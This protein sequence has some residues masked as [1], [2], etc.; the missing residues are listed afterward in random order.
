MTT[1]TLSGI[2]YYPVKGCAGT[3]LP[4][5][6][7]TAAG[8]PHDRAY[9]IADEK[10]D[11][12]W[13]GGDPALALITPELTGGELTLRAPGRE[14]V[15]A[16]G[17]EVHAWLTDVL[18]AVSTLVRCPTGNAGR[19]HVVSRSSL[20]A[21]NR[22][23]AAR[24]AAPVPMDRFRPN[25]VVDGW[26]VPHTED[27]VARVVVGGAELAFTEATIRCAVTMVDQRTGLRS[28]PEPLRTLAD[29]RR[30]AGG[31]LAFGAYFEVRRAGRVAVGD[32]VRGGA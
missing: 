10:G 13:Q 19:L 17:K 24:D 23:I 25:L 27:G 11:L 18:G 12:R 6:T 4:T 26:D 16:D 8:L 7:L 14:P 29:Y 31:G 20:D 1:G 30:V 15:P 28:G 32:E 5:A 22:R 21:L 9:A 3:A 2:T